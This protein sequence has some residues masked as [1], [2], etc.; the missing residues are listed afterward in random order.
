MKE[1]LLKE[2]SNLKHLNISPK[3]GN[4]VFKYHFIEGA[5]LEIVGDASGKF[6]VEFIDQSTDKI[7]YTD[8]ISNNMWCKA[9]AKFYVNWLIKVTN[10]DTNKVI[11]THKYNANDQRVY[12]HLDS[13]ALGDTLAWFPQ[14][15]EFRKKHNCKLICSTFHNDWFEK[16]YPEI[17]FTTPGS[18]VHNIYAMYGVGWFYND[19]DEID[20]TRN[21]I[22]FRDQSLI[23][24]AS[25]IL[26]LEFNEVKPNLAFEDKGKQIEGKY[27]C[28]APHGSSHAK[29]WNRKGGWQ[30][31]IDY[32][33]IK[34]YKVV[35]ITS[36]PLGNDFHDKKL[37]GTLK[38]VINKTGDIH[39]SDRANDLRYADAFIGIGSGLSWL[40]WAMNCPTILISGFSEPNSEFSDCERI[41]SPSPSACTGCFNKE[42]L[43]AGDWDWCPYYKNTER[44]YECTKTITSNIVVDSLNKLLGIS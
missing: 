36:E 31:V 1:V 35:M 43:D 10:V 8:T 29:Y 38:N 39:L 14:V 4:Y 34:G 37:G 13:K 6:K 3:E 24:T 20:Y 41:T 27:V 26:G 25:D 16:E 23:K 42:R 28:I 33:N 5:F 7:L 2:Y 15:E 44:M 11:F 9:A 18:V 40:S 12:I 21:P 17:E 22:D 32:L 19:N 30:E